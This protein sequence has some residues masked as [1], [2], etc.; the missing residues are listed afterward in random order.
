MDK[1]IVK[2]WASILAERLER[3][4]SEIAEMGLS[5]YD[6]P[7]NE[8][9]EI[10]FD[11]GDSMHF[12]FAFFVVDEDREK[13]AV[14]TEHSGYFEFPSKYLQVTSTRVD[15]YTGENFEE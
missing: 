4:A 10:R 3:P 7:A 8:E 1:E 11:S 9:V 2:T 14:F 15:I 6:F 5:A 13:I 12:K